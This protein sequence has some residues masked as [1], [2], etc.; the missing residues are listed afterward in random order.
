MNLQ[1]ARVHVKTTVPPGESLVGV[2]PFNVFR[3]ERV[4]LT[5]N[6]HVLLLTANHVA[7]PFDGR[8]HD[9]RAKVGG[10]TIGIGNHI[11]L[12]VRNQ[13]SEPQDIELQIGGSSIDTA[14]APPGEPATDIGCKLVLGLFAQELEPEPWHP[15]PIPVPELLDLAADHYASAKH[16]AASAFDQAVMTGAK[17]DLD[18]LDQADARAFRMLQLLQRAQSLA[19]ASPETLPEAGRRGDGPDEAALGFTPEQ[20][21]AMRDV[22]KERNGWTDA[23]L[24]AHIAEVARDPSKRRLIPEGSALFAPGDPSATPLTPDE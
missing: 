15:N 8:V 22:L 19:D 9:L 16:A 14:P 23:Q 4:K 10:P 2:L 3:L 21:A 13:S 6:E 17:E 24:D 18:L 1:R 20:W 7:V 11:S 5:P 12:F